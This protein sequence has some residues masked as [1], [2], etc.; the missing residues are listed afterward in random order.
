MPTK[1]IEKLKQILKTKRREYR[2]LRTRVYLLR[3]AK[4]YYRLAK[5][6]KGAEREYYI[7]L[8]NYYYNLYLRHAKKYPVKKVEIARKPRKVD[9]TVPVI[10]FLTAT[11][12]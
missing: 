12:L 10:A 11:L 6:A 7:S 3:K 2:L 9:W 4:I 5:R 8:A 1:E